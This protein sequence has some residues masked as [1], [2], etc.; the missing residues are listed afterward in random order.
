MLSGIGPPAHLA[1]H[2]IPLTHALPGVG[3]HL[4]DHPHAHVRFRVVR[5]ESLNYL[6]PR[7]VWHNLRGM[8]ELARWVA[9]GRGPLTSNVRPFHDSFSSSECHILR[10]WSKQ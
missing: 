2:A 10:R 4:M 9:T 6:Y 8:W 1:S 7:T 3:T 5:G